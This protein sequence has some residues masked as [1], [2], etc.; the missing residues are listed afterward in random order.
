MVLKLCVHTQVLSF[1]EPSAK[2]GLPGGLREVISQNDCGA[3]CPESL[4]FCTGRTD[5]LRPVETAP[6]ATQP[7][8]K[9]DLPRSCLLVLVTNRQQICLAAE[10]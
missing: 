2:Q 4:H 7:L 3:Q 8:G 1:S 9:K 5:G 6:L 10:V